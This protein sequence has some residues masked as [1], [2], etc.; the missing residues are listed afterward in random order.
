HLP[1]LLELV[2]RLLARLLRE[3]GLLDL[4]LDLRELVLAFRVA[5]LFLDRPHLLVKKKL[6]LGLL[7]LAL[8][9]RAD[10]LPPAEPKSR[11]RSGRAPSRAARYPTWPPGSPPAPD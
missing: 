5:D 4:V 9:A 6:A 10:A 8:D 2:R 11:C 1:E 3:L 7:H